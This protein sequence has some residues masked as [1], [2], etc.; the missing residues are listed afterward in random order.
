M[1]SEATRA[2][3]WDL[4][5]ITYVDKDPQNGL[6]KGEA[7]RIRL[8]REDLTFWLE[9]ADSTH[10]GAY[11]MSADQRSLTLYQDQRPWWF[12][13]FLPDLTFIGSKLGYWIDGSYRCCQHKTW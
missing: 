3:T 5:V 10:F 11:A 1:Q 8:Y 12:F 6:H 4:K 2:P 13:C 9:Y 7:V